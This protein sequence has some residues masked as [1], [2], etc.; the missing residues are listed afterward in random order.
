[1]LLEASPDSLWSSQDT[2]GRN[3]SQT[4]LSVIGTA[5]CNLAKFVFPLPASFNT[6]EPSITDSF[7]FA[8]EISPVPNSGSYVMAS[9]DVKLLFYYVP[10]EENLKKFSVE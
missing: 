10:L 1:M 8:Q 9:F 3:P 7:S 5:G 6:N 4:K 2:Q